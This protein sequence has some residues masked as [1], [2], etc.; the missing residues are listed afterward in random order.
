VKPKSPVK[1]KA[2]TTS[3]SS[4][5]DEKTEKK[6]DNND[7]LKEALDQQF[8]EH[9]QKC[10]SPEYKCD[11]DLIC[12]VSGNVCVDKSVASLEPGYLN[13][14]GKKIVGSKHAIEQL[15]KKLKV[16]SPKKPKAFSSDDTKY[17]KALTVAKKISGYKDD[18]FKDF[19]L[20]QIEIFTEGFPIHEMRVKK[21]IIQK[22][23]KAGIS[24]EIEDI[25]PLTLEQLHKRQKIMSSLLVDLRKKYNRTKAIETL[26]SYFNINPSKFGKIKDEKIMEMLDMKV[27][28]VEELSKEEKKS[29]SP[30][31]PASKPAGKGKEEKPET[32]EESE[33]EK[34]KDKRKSQ[35]DVKVDDIKQVLSRVIS[36]DTKHV[37]EFG[38]VENAVLKCMGL[39]S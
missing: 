2:I 9:K 26:A 19:S 25:S 10:S 4:T 13:W 15:R 8:S 36:G 17:K 31:K 1:A 22:A 5:E 28:S 30:K 18:Y 6:G 39:L 29:V 32:E 12:D 14:G 24:V 3:S 34:E 21:D 33:D 16:D 7:L 38:K 23:K 35:D 27:A 37:K 11:G 20:E